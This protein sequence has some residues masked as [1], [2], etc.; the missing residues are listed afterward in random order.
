MTMKHYR[1]CGPATS[2]T[3]RKPGEEDRTIRLH[4]GKRIELPADHPYTATLVARGH[5]SEVAQPARPPA[6]KSKLKEA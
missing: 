2:L 3:I 1:Y 4:S 6:R 5:L